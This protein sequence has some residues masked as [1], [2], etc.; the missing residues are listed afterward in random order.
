MAQR[1]HGTL[2]AA[3][4]ATATVTAP[5]ETGTRNLRSLRHVEVLNRG[6]SGDIFFTVDGT[7]PVVNAAD[8]YVVLPGGGVEV[9]VPGADTITVKLISAGTPAYSVGGKE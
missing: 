3:T 6:P 2:T 1:V 7:T 5:A 8:T 9:D 4:V